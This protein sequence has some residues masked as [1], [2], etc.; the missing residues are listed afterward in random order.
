MSSSG[1]EKP[2]G[3]F[4]WGKDFWKTRCTLRFSLASWWWGGGTL[5]GRGAGY[6]RT[7]YTDEPRTKLPL[8]RRRVGIYRGQRVGRSN[9]LHREVVQHNPNN[10]WRLWSVVHELSEQGSLRHGAPE[11]QTYT[12]HDHYRAVLVQ[13]FY[14]WNGDLAKLYRWSSRFTVNNNGHHSSPDLLRRLLTR[15]AGIAHR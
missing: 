13:R 12:R 5:N 9:V 4:I 11:G 10:R 7:E 2:A 6:D 14:G 3:F 8:C 1:R 15:S